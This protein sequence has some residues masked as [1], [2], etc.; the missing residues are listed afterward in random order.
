M[1]SLTTWWQGLPEKKNLESRACWADPLK[2]DSL[3]KL[4]A[5]DLNNNSLI[6]CKEAAQQVPISK[7][8]FFPGKHVAEKLTCIP[9]IYHCFYTTTIW[10]Q[11]ILCFKVGELATKLYAK[12]YTI[13]LHSNC[14]ILHFADKNYTTGGCRGCEV[15]KPELLQEGW[16]GSKA[17]TP[18]RPPSFM[19]NVLP[20]MLNLDRVTSNVWSNIMLIIVSGINILLVLLYLVVYLL[21][22]KGVLQKNLKS[23]QRRCRN[24][25]SI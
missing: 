3:T 25:L 24:M 11:E 18:I 17:N 2:L 14:K 5:L 21:F 9:H 1:R 23:F 6:I 22:R 13:F 20:L 15:L 16:Q 19:R 8:I 12:F 4:A 7:Q 10:G